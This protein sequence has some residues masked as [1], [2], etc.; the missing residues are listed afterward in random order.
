MCGI[1]SSTANTQTL[2]V[3]YNILCTVSR[4]VEEEKAAS[5]E[6]ERREEE[7]HKKGKKKENECKQQNAKT[8]SHQRRMTSKRRPSKVP[9]KNTNKRVT[10]KAAFRELHRLCSYRNKMQENS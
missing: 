2:Y 6:H 4:K 5:A 9:R 1:H 3:Q 10:D 7:T 8:T